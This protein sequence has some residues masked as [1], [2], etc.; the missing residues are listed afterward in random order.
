MSTLVSIQ[1][2]DLITNS[3]ADING[4]F[5]AL[6]TDKLETSV[7]DTDTTLA[8][9]S[10]S[11]VP[12]QKAVKAYVDAQGFSDASTTVK[13]VVEEATEAEVL[14]GTTTGST[15]ARL[16]VNP[17][18]QYRAK[19]PVS[20]AFSGTSPT[21]YTDLDL[22]SI[23]GARSSVVL[24]KVVAGTVTVAFHFRKNGESGAD[25]TIDTSS[26]A[27]RTGLLETTD[28][29]Y[30]M[31]VT[32]SAGVVEWFTTQGGVGQASTTCTITV[33]AYW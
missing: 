27:S 15:G 4:N 24:L 3:R 18:T 8:A 1:S 28:V 6:N 21:S 29:G 30:V 13:G 9:N 5:S 32:D 25:H 10:D 22:S 11:K 23:V 26:H 7:L 20:T 16:F 17:S 12:T 14:A 31:V 2:T 19:F 33:E